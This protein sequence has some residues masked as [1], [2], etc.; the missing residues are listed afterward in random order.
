MAKIIDGIWDKKI[1]PFISSWYLFFARVSF[2]IIYFYFGLVKLIGNS[3]AGP[4]V[5]ALERQTLPFIPFNTFYLSFSLF[6]MLI[7]VLFL[8]PRAT[9]LVFILFIV[10]IATTMMPLFVLPAYSWQ[11]VFIPTI[12]G[13]YMI[14]NL[15]LIA[16]ACSILV[17]TKS[18]K[19]RRLI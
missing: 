9:K 10:H 19:S 13:Q 18:K 14:K 5:Y 11:S 17:N 8:F 6:E 4:L 2:F 3:S 12:E 15:V 7:G 16:L 1:I